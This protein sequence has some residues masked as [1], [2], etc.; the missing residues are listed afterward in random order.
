MGN[1]YVGSYLVGS[2]YVHSYYYIIT[3]NCIHVTELQELEC[4]PAE[5]LPISLNER[6]KNINVCLK[7]NSTSNFSCYHDSPPEEVPSNPSMYCFNI[8]ITNMGGR[9]AFTNLQ[10]PSHLGKR[11]L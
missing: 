1:R 5:A 11:T 4:P 8:F 9:T 10:F 6:S 2:Y 3:I 7:E